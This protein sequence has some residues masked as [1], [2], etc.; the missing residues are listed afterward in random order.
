[1]ELRS[2]A[3]VRISR[4]ALAAL[5]ASL[6]ALA[7]AACDAGPGQDERAP[8]KSGERPPGSALAV[9][10]ADV[11]F[12]TSDGVLLS[13][14]LAVPRPRAPAVILVHQFGSDRHDW[15]GFV[16]VLNRAGFATLAY[17]TR[18][19]GR[20]LSRWPSKQRYFPP[21]DE[22]RYVEAM[23]RDVA[24]G[25]RFLRARRD[26]DAERIAIV[27][28]SIGANVAYASSASARASV[29]LSPVPL[30]DTLR[31]RRPRPRGVLFISSRLEAAAVLELAPTVREPTL[32]MLARDPEAHGIAL[33]REPAVRGA[34]LDWLRSHL[35][36]GRRDGRGR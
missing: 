13:G 32:N 23:P 26:V 18:G 28:A 30:R 25:L 2:R 5:A 31:P 24:A 33:L 16:P 34:I 35:F 14:S 1:V 10:R 21:R 4:S 7:L 11:G 8:K 17:D 6:V 36:A 29:A 19:M 27:G 22:E 20:S 9:R 3:A 12:A 15:D